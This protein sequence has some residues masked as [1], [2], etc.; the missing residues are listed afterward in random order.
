M[1]SGELKGFSP[2]PHTPWTGRGPWSPHVSPIVWEW[3]QDTHVP[4]G[5]KD[6]PHKEAC[7]TSTSP[8]WEE[9]K[10][11]KTTGW[12]PT[13]QAAIASP[14]IGQQRKCLLPQGP[15]L[16]SFPNNHLPECLLMVTPIPFQKSL[17]PFPGVPTIIK[18]SAWVHFLEKRMFGFI[19]T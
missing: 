16:T 7:P 4:L 12:S 5:W 13:T 15:R 9:T 10:F 18:R 14:G 11:H 17:N 1:N 19:P 8:W 3:G 2:E 6:T